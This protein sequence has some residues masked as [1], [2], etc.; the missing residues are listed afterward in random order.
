[1]ETKIDLSRINELCLPYKKRP[2]R[3]IG[4]KVVL[5][6]DIQNN[7]GDKM[8][9]GEIAEILQSFRGYGLKTRHEG[10]TIYITRVS[11]YEVRFLKDGN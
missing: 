7:A 1:M 8:E 4:A 9:A 11:H 2:K 5:V 3:I 10:R 6:A